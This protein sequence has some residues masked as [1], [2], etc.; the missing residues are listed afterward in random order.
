M[1]TSKGLNST[2]AR[3]QV[4]AYVRKLLGSKRQEGGWVAASTSKL[5]L[6][7]GTSTSRIA[8]APHALP[9]QLEATAYSRTAKSESSANSSVAGNAWLISPI[10]TT[11]KSILS[12][13]S[14]GSSNNQTTK[15]RTGSRQTFEIV[16]SISPET[17]ARPQS[18]N[19]SSAGLNGV[20]SHAVT[21][22]NAL[23]DSLSAKGGATAS[24]GSGG[25]SSLEDRQALVTALRRSLSE[26]RG[27]A[28]VLNEFQDGL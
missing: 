17:G 20:T 9:T 14:G 4:Q 7:K 5:S 1:G 11:V 28:D 8:E 27:I 2:Q 24:R 16:E 15:Y 6:P 18:V 19:E 25:T 13:F 10:A 3:T 26:S 21:A 12:L 23:A 22:G